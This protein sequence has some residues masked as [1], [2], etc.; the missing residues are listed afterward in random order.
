MSTY[1]IADSVS[2]RIVQIF[3][4][5]MMCRV[6][7]ADLLRQV[8]LEVS[9][10]EPDTLVLT[11]DYKKS[12]DEFHKKL[13]VEAE[14]LQNASKPS[15]TILE[16]LLKMKEEKDDFTKMWDQQEKFMRLL[17]EKR[18]FPNFPVDMLS[19]Q[20][21]K[22]LD[23]ISMHLIKEVFESTQHLKIMK[24]LKSMLVS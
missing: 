15:T 17:Q 6:D 5:A 21:Q 22:L 10:T 11:S 4:E 3:Q 7:G 19:K 1:K 12:V 24:I 14:K 23:E 9:S 20:G 13:L 2:A 18:N 8:R 16:S